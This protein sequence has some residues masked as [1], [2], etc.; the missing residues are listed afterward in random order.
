M[1]TAAPAL[2]QT[3]DTPAREAPSQGSPPQESPP[4]G[5]PAAADPASPDVGDQ[6]R[7]RE[8]QAAFDAGAKAS[9]EGPA[10]VTLIDQGVLKLPDGYAFIPREEGDRILRAFGNTASG[11]SFIG[12]VVSPSADWIITIRYIKDG[13][14]KDDDARNWNADELLQ[15]I[16]E[17]TEAANADRAERGFPQLEVLRWIEAPTWD[18]ETHRLIWSLLA[19]EKGQPDATA[20]TVNY[21]TYALGRDGYFSLNLLTTSQTVATDK[22]AARDM[23]EALSYNSGKRYEDFN[24]STDHI[25]EYGLLALIGGVAAKKLGLFAIIA[26]FVLK[27]AKVI[28]VAAFA[29]GASLWNFLRRRVKG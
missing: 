12:L 28:A 8:L 11:P 23:L 6:A 18:S 21:N 13:Y 9:T 29:G 17:G 4:Q 14:V 24:A 20:S 25:A 27:F 2:A 26:A 16:K 19:K 5:S 22:E 7:A 10:D 1:A 15:T 3:E